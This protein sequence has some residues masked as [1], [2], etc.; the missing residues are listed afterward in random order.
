M[1]HGDKRMI[2]RGCTCN[3]CTLVREMYSR[4][5]TPPPPGGKRVPATKVREHLRVLRDAGMQ[6]KEIAEVSGYHPNTLRNLR[7]G[8]AHYTLDVT[9][10]DILSIPVPSSSA[11]AI[12][13]A[14][15]RGEAS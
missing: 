6:L 7:D 2:L 4:P 13:E 10:E 8:H 11:W 5:K 3:L 12:G 9:E 15:L 14:I 1:I